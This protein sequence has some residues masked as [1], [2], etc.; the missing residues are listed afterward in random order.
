VAS[1]A[2]DST[3][4]I[5]TR[6]GRRLSAEIAARLSPDRT[7]RATLFERN[8]VERLSWDLVVR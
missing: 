3:T 8:T 5:A 6:L 7:R 4:Y 2:R 1:G